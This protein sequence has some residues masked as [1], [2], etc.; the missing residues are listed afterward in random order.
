MSMKVGETVV[1][2]SFGDALRYASFQVGAI[3]TGTGYGTFDFERWPALSQ[4]LLVVLMFFGGCAGSTTGGLKQ[5]RF[6]LLIKQGYVEIKRFILPNAVL[7]V[8]VG[9]RVVPQEVMTNVLGFFFLFI[10]IFAIVTCMMAALGLDLVSAAASTI[11]T[12]ANI[13]PGLGS[14]GP[15]D[16]YAHIPMVGKLILSFCMLL[17]RLELYT[18]LV[19]FAPELWRK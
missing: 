14:V 18:V 15:T 10:G 17:G 9:D 13:G 11:A 1:Y 5:I 12:M 3:I 6:L 16:N 2:D 8:K 4:F 19:L 7:P